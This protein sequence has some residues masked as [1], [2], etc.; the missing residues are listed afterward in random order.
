MSP[1][2]FSI[3]TP[4]YNAAATVGPAIESALAQTEPDW[5]LVVVDDGS[6][7]D[8]AAR[9][10]P[11]LSDARIRLVR[12]ENRG[13]SG[14]RN[15]AIATSRGGCVALLD[16]DD[17]LMPDYLATMGDALDGDTAAGFAYTD[18]WLLDDRSRRIARRTVMAARRPPV[19]EA[20]D[21]RAA[22]RKLI[23]CNFVYV[24]ATVRRDALDRVGHFDTSLQ[25]LEDVD[26]WLRLTA[27]G[28]RGVRA[29]GVH[30]I[31]RRRPGS[32]SSSE[33]RMLRADARVLRKVA[34]SLERD[35]PLRA[36]ALRR[37]EDV[38]GRLAALSGAK[39]ARAAG[40]RAVRAAGRLRRRAL[41][42]RLWYS[43]PP[44]EVALA[45]PDLTS[46]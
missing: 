12:Q 37:A 23:E 33:Q 7:D 43:S 6:T 26:L 42:R 38:A 20:L 41:D 27:A 8:T 10:E 2:R 21:A 1:P 29:P 40:L 45:F 30:A 11:Y 5:E 14:A 39:P 9:V 35:D 36:L 28:Y 16:A 17:L 15:T 18:A 22:L 13:L 25:A 31:Y 24:S 4:A 34:A 44:P 46:R 19:W 3:L 32:L